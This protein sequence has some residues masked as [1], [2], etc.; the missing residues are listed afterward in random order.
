[1]VHSGLRKNG[2][3]DLFHPLVFPLAY[4]GVSFILPAWRMIVEG[5]SYLIFDFWDLSPKTAWL[6]AIAVGGYCAGSVLVMIPRSQ[7]SDL[8]VSAPVRAFSYVRLLW[9]ARIAFLVPLLLSLDNV[10]TGL[11]SRGLDQTSFGLFDSVRALALLVTPV[12][13]ILMAMARSGLGPEGRLPLFKSDAFLVALF[14]VASGA[15]GNRGGI[16]PTI[17]A[18]GYVAT[19]RKS[20]FFAAVGMSAVMFVSMAWVSHFRSSSSNVTLDT[21]LTDLSV[22]TYSTGVTANFVDQSGSPVWGLTYLDALL[23]QIPAP[24][25]NT[26]IGPPVSTGSYRFRQMIGFSDPNQ[27]FGYSIP[28]EGYLNFGAAGIFLSCLF[29]GA[30]FAIAY[31]MR[32]WPIVR[33]SNAS[34]VLLLCNLPVALRSDALGSIKGFLYPVIL[35]GL[36]LFIA[37]SPVKGMSGSRRRMR[38]PGAALSTHR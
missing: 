6:L 36:A 22:A 5:K 12:C 2:K 31:R 13:V 30:M 17:L 26:L 20:R 29:V 3:L 32:G 34:Y 16:I 11:A 4:V 23:R 33:L 38:H 37:R 18:L 25:I 14:I 24:L 21:A 9:T 28:A 1:M 8:A 27:G 15:A 35:F 10:R 7:R 19:R